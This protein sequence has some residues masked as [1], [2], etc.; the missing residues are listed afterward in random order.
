MYL[1]LESILFVLQ[2]VTAGELSID[3][4]PAGTLSTSIFVAGVSAVRRKGADSISGRS[5]LRDGILSTVLTSRFMLTGPIRQV[6]KLYKP[7]DGPKEDLT[8][9]FMPSS[10]HALN[11]LSLPCPTGTKPTFRWRQ[12]SRTAWLARN[13]M[14]ALPSARLLLP[15][16]LNLHSWWHE[17]NDGCPLL[18]K[19]LPA[20]SSDRK[21]LPKT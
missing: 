6:D 5:S 9:R 11:R 3:P 10:M 16:E 20:P 7:W 14:I 18:R 21:F 13:P 15:R 12:S 19:A 17:P 4:K 2:R 1:A 8:P